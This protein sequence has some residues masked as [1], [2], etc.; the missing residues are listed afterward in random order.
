MNQHKILEWFNNNFEHVQEL[1]DKHKDT[2]DKIYN[3]Y[4]VVFYTAIKNE[5]FD[6]YRKEVLN[7]CN[8]ATGES[9]ED[10]NNILQNKLE[11]LWNLK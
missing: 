8:E 10:C 1:C 11:K 7:Q 9:Y 3:N 6:N 4:H 2:F 5:A